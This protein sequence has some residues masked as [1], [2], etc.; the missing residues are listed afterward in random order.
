MKDFYTVTIFTENKP[1]VLYKISGLFLRR[2][3][4]IESLTV[5]YSK[6]TDQ[7]RF[8]IV[9]FA[10]EILV[11]KIVKQLYRIIEVIKVIDSKN[12]DLIYKEVALF[13]VTAR[14]MKRRQ[15]IEHLVKIAKDARMITV[16][17]SYLVIEKTGSEKEVEDFYQLL[18]H[19]GIKEFIRS[20]RIA[21][22]K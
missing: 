1:G 16:H 22:F 7:S 11:E 14:D 10:E 6:D 18:D 15:E 19:F 20:G 9:V 17:K 2:K 12:R 13:K 21:V 8:T 5:S 3:I 4:N